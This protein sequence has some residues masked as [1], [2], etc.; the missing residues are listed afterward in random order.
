MP[1][2]FKSRAALNPYTPSES[3]RDLRVDLLRGYCVLAMVVDHI[4][5]PSFLYPLTGGNRFYTSAAEAFIFISGLVMGLVYH[6][7][8]D[9]DG[10]AGAIGRAMERGF[11]LYLLTITLTLVFIPL[12]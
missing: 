4:G 10:L 2:F 8:V 5:G 12:W 3:G 11:A 7:M 6:R 9:R 1:A